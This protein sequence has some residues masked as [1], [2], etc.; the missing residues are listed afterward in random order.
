MFS[1]RDICQP[2][3]LPPNRNVCVT[4]ACVVFAA[5]GGSKHGLRAVEGACRRNPRKG[6]VRF[7]RQQHVFCL[8]QCGCHSAQRDEHVGAQCAVPSTSSGQRHSI[9]RELAVLAEE[10]P[11]GNASG[12]LRLQFLPTPF[13]PCKSPSRGR[14]S[15]G[16]GN[17][18]R[19]QSCSISCMVSESLKCNGRCASAGYLF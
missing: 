7:H 11:K 4:A 5:R 17:K 6:H 16:F 10:L 19:R 12:L 18:E 13:L 3:G 9:V 8:G 14:S 1:C 15:I 2:G